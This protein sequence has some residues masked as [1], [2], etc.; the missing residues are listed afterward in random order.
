MD[1][2][3]DQTDINEVDVL[4]HFHNAMCNKK[5]MTGSFSL[6]SWV[7]SSQC[8]FLF[9]CMEKVSLG[10]FKIRTGSKRHFKFRI[11]KNHYSLSTFYTSGTVAMEIFVVEITYPSITVLFLY[12]PITWHDKLPLKVLKWF[13]IVLHLILRIMQKCLRTQQG[14]HRTPN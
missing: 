6:S 12:E 11:V 9:L 5:G 7:L 10:K 1:H 2:P 4:H 14:G 13:H 8:G 3:L